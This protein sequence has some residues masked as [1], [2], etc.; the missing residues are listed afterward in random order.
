MLTGLVVLTPFTLTG[1]LEDQ[2][3]ERGLPSLEGFDTRLAEGTKILKVDC[4]P[5][6]LSLSSPGLF[7]N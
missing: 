5:Q 6:R 3:L 1:R 7:I 4:R 2:E